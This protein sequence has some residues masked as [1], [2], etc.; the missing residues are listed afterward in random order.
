VA[1]HM[2]LCRTPG[3]RTPGPRTPDPR[4]ASHMAASHTAASLMAGRRTVAPCP[5]AA[6]LTAGRPMAG[7]YRVASP[8]CRTGAGCRRA[9]TASTGLRGPPCRAGHRVGTTGRGRA[10]GTRTPTAG[11]DRPRRQAGRHRAAPFPEDRQESP[12][13]EDRQESPF[14]EDRLAV[15]FPEDRLRVRLA[16]VHSLAP[17]PGYPGNLEYPGLRCCVSIRPP[18]R[19]ST[20]PTAVSGSARRQNHRGR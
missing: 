5:M 9:R 6:R 19:A 15:P 20:F 1:S 3:P 10:P 16:G 12:F 7:R 11:A 4:T 17:S 14:P 8:G 2:G 13:P 18:D